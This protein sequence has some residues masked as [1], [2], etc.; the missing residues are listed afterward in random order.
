MSDELVKD[1][2]G[3]DRSLLSKS[4]ILAFDNFQCDSKSQIEGTIFAFPRMYWK[5][6]I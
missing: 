6:Y 2:F 5:I 4:L 1:Y 3:H